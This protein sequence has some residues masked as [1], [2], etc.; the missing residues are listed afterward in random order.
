MKNRLNK[1]YNP[2][3]ILKDYFVVHLS[4]Y[5]GVIL[6]Y[7]YQCLCMS[8]SLLSIFYIFLSPQ[9]SQP[10][11]V[12]I[13]FL[14]LFPKYN[15]IRRYYRFILRKISNLNLNKSHQYKFSTI[16]HN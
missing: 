8:D 16:H 14:I 11:K 9:K 12:C 1:F 4:I 13:I 3:Y 6:Q 7:K 10:C 2:T 5:V 15:Q